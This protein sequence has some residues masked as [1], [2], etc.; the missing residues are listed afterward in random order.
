MDLSYLSNVA[1]VS[2]FYEQNRNYFDVYLP[3]IVKSL[4]STPICKLEQVLENLYGIF[5]FNL[6]INVLKTIID[7]NEGKTLSSKR[8]SSNWE[9]CLTT[10]GKELLGNIVED[11]RKTAD[12]LTFLYR[13]ANGYFAQKG[14]AQLS[15][16]EMSLAISKF[17]CQPGTFHEQAGNPFGGPE[18]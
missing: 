12:E 15:D 18:R 3:F 16:S 5:Q 11:E 9:I 7:E 1:L 6:P 17:L 14:L 2:T 10:S 13:S 4:E 8:K